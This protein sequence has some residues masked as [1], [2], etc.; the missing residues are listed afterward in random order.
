MS[1]LQSAAK[2]GVIVSL[3]HTFE[4]FGLRL[5]KL[6]NLS[7]ALSWTLTGAAIILTIGQFVIRLRIIRIFQLDDAFHGLAC[8][9]LVAYVAI[10]QVTFPIEYS[11]DSFITGKGPQPSLGEFETFLHNYVASVTMFW[12]VIYSMKFSFLSF[13]YSLFDISRHFMNR[14]WIVLGF[15]I[16]MFSINFVAVFWICGTPGNL[17]NIREWQCIEI[18]LYRAL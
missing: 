2:E 13:Y 10:Q 16:L 5:W 6:S 7:Q 4:L 17:Y 1:S 11:L 3:A 18:S 9:V 14:W 8:L 12:V 15:T